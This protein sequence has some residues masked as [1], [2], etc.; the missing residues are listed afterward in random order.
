MWSACLS[1][2]SLFSIYFWTIASIRIEGIFSGS[3]MVNAN[4]EM[5]CKALYNDHLN[6]MPWDWG[7][8]F[9]GFHVRICMPCNQNL[10]AMLLTC[11]YLTFSL[12]KHVGSKSSRFDCVKGEQITSQWVKAHHLQYLILVQLHS[13]KGIIVFSPNSRNLLFFWHGHGRHCIWWLRGLILGSWFAS[14]AS[15]L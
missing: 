10:P 8:L 6:E 12:F 15:E 2:I 9:Q 4:S 11:F 1:F 13:R 5:P 14:F 7:A 3:S